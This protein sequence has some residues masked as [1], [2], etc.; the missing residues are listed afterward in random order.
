MQVANSFS[1]DFL[2]GFV[3]RCQQMGLN[4]DQAEEL[5][6]KHAN[7]TLLAQPNINEGFRQA[8]AEYDGN[9]TK[10]AMMR[11]LNPNA[12]AVAEECRIKYGSDALSVQMRSAMGLPEPSW[13]TVPEELQ[14][15]A[16]SL[17]GLLDEYDYLPLNQK[18]LLASLVGAGI[19]GAGRAVAPSESDDIYDRGVTKRLLLGGLRGGMMGAGAGMGAG[20][21]S[22]MASHGTPPVPG[23][24]RP[25]YGGDMSVPA[26]LI[27]GGAGALAARSLMGNLGA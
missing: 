5:F 16:S 1:P 6:R 19:G 22:S 12:L 14:K 18:V 4:E 26:N 20:L 23:R 15:V 11:W 21:G 7:N 8:I 17:S 25:D 2:E 10:A 24:R 13:D 27:G 3:E 9:L